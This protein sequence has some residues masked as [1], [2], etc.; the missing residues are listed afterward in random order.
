MKHIKYPKKREALLKHW[1]GENWSEEDQQN[2]VRARN[3]RQCGRYRNKHREAYTKYTRDYQ[4]QFRA[5]NP[6]YYGWKQYLRHHNGVGMTY[7][8]YIEYRENKR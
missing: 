4:K 3:T 8:E 5:K 6:Y 1:H 2:F 7:E